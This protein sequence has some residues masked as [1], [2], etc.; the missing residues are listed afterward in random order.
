MK[1]VSIDIGSNEIKAAV[2]D[3]TGKPTK[4]PYENNGVSS[5][6]MPSEVF[7]NGVITVGEQAMM[8]GYLAPENLVFDWQND[9]MSDEI[10]RNFFSII[11][12][13]AVKYYAT[14]EIGAVILFGDRDNNNIK[15]VARDVFHEVQSKNSYEVLGLSNN[16][17]NGL[18][19]VVDFGY[20]SLKICLMESGKMVSFIAENIGFSSLD[21]VEVVNVEVDGFCSD[22]E[23]AIYGQLLDRL[24]ISLLCNERNAIV[25]YFEDKC[26][27]SIQS[28][29]DVYMSKYLLKCWSSCT[30]SIRNI[31]R[32]WEDIDSVII[33]GGAGNYYKILDSFT[34]FKTDYLG[35]SINPFV[36][37]AKDSGWQSA[38]SALKLPLRQENGIIIRN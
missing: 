20:S 2:R 32:C 19:L 30:A 12:E 13:N 5:T 37:R 9:R 35:A 4:L 29:F 26:K 17:S 23:V 1:W 27:N 6:Y 11:K 18:S 25:S 10:L 34:K 14:N 31:S 22:A 36:I 3:N 33:T 15:N 8:L 28:I 21:M 7:N 38:F 16:I 24:R